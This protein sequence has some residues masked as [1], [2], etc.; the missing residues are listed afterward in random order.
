VTWLALTTL[1]A[2]V[3]DSVSTNMSQ[4]FVRPCG[5]LGDYLYAEGEAVQQGEYET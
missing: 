2:P 1:G 5:Q 4:E 3:L